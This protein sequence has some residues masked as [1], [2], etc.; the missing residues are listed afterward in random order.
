MSKR[1]ILATLPKGNPQTVTVRRLFYALVGAGVIKKTEIE[2]QRL[3]REVGD[4]VTLQ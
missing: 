2:Y 3:T 4:T 1:Y